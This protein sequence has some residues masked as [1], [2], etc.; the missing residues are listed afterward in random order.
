MYQ[1]NFINFK[2]NLILIKFFLN[3]LYKILKTC[4]LNIETNV[5]L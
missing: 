1:V 3:I 4:K 5:E 2:I